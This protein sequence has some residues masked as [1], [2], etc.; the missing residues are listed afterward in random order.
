L[1]KLRA[2]PECLCELST[3]ADMTL[4]AGMR[5][6]CERI[7]PDRS[8][9]VFNQLRACLAVIALGKYG[10]TELNFFGDLDVVFVYRDDTTAD[11]L[12]TSDTSGTASFFV[13]IAD[14][15]NSVLSENLQGGR[16]FVLDARLRPHGRNAP[17]ATPLSQYLKYLGEEAEVWELQA[18][19]RA[20]CVWG[21]CE[22]LKEIS[23]DAHQRTHKLSTASLLQE[24]VSMRTR[25]DAT[26]NDEGGSAEVNFKRAP[27]GLVDIEFLLQWLSLSG[28]A[29]VPANYFQA[30]EEP[31]VQSAIGADAP[32]LAASYTWLRELETAVRLVT[33]TG[34]STFPQDTIERQAVSKL[35]GYPDAIELT[36]SLRLKMAQIRTVYERALQSNVS[37]K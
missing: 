15:L 36:H 33:S 22:I 30:L 1:L 13:G 12:A 32:L 35:M 17:H 24:I 25:L 9:E 29:I 37:Q 2:L 16:A 10:G 21:E 7:A 11:K 28:R 27:G 19:T 20:R 23:A 4:D 5:L 18:L 3:T 34:S 26:A 31:G 6:V 14:A 8:L